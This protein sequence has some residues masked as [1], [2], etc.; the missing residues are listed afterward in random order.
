[1]N[2]FSIY[3]FFKC[4]ETD[5]NFVFIFVLTNL[6]VNFNA[7]KRPAPKGILAHSFNA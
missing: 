5:R 2:K 4:V 3:D 1:M 7:K 6:T